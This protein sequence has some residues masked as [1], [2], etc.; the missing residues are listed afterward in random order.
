MIE[1]VL[2]LN[3]IK[4][5]VYRND[6]AF[7]EAISLTLGLWSETRVLISFLWDH[8]GILLRPEAIV[9]RRSR[10]ILPMLR[11]HGLM[12]VCVRRLHLTPE[13]SRL[14]WRY[15]ANV[16]TQGHYLLL[17]RLLSAGPSIYIVLK[18]H[19]KRKSTPAAGHVTYLKGPTLRAKRRPL[20]LRSLAGPPIANILSYIHASDDPADF[21]RELAI[22]FPGSALRQILSEAAAG[23]DRTCDLLGALGEAELYAPKGILSSDHI[24]SGKDWGL[25]S[26]PE[27]PLVQ[28]NWIEIIKLA[29]TNRSY[30]SGEM[31][32]VRSAMIP[33][34]KQYLARL[35]DHLIFADVAPGF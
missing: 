25:W 18:D 30:V 20:H 22:L 11:A 6:I 4:K 26:P 8:T 33:D 12:P 34:D 2:T 9:A 3:P 7:G 10:L 15:Q 13:Q 19:S 21:L 27:D 17:Q 1:N 14:M 32:D 16:M 23:Q 28:R 29:Q 35:D 5:T 24:T 31:Y